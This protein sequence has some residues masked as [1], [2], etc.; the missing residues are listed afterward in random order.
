MRNYPWAL[1]N[2]LPVLSGFTF[3]F[4]LN[5]LISMYG[6]WGEYAGVADYGRNVLSLFLFAFSV[7]LLRRC[8][9][10]RDRRLLFLSIIC[11]IL[12]SI[13]CVWGTWLVYRLTLFSSGRDIF[14]QILLVFGMTPV[15][16]ALIRELFLF[17][18]FLR[19]RCLQPPP[20][21]PRS[22]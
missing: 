10:E 20:R 12:L 17:L 16:A 2:T 6:Q 4:S 1:K 21:P 19:T 14:L 13:S 7:F 11:G 22:I 15:C 9:R 3:A 18:E 8:L 5:Y